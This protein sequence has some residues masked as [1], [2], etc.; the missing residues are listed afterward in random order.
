MSATAIDLAKIGRLYLNGGN[1]NGKQIVSKEW[2][3]K[4]ITPNLAENHISGRKYENHQYHW[5]S[6]YRGWHERD[7]TGAYR[8]NDSISALRF[9]EESAFARYEVRK[10]KYAD[11]HEYHWVAI[12][13]SPEFKAFGVM[14]QYV[15]VDPEKK[16]IMVR[17]GEQWERGNN[18]VSLT[19]ILTRRYPVLEKKW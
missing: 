10:I 16:I 13:F 5:Y 19:R 8:F 18:V 17:L 9:A 11:K 3:E 6:L 14:S 1:W 12:D 15:Y 7:S 4:S 2:V